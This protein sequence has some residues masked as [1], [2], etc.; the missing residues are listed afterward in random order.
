MV[1]KP[2]QSIPLD[3]G[4]LPGLET[5]AVHVDWLDVNQFRVGM[6]YLF[7]GPNAVFP[8]RL[9]FRTDP[10]LVNGTYG[11]GTDT[12]QAIGKVFTG[13]FGMKFGNIWLDL[14]YEYGNTV[15]T[16]VEV[17]GFTMK[18]NEITHN[19]LAS[20]IVHF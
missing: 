6:E 7:V 20:C 9:G 12:T 5:V 18:E 17:A 15:W 14:T 4:K 11:T 1:D 2:Y 10:K 16:D 3:G 8:V 19:I 13:G